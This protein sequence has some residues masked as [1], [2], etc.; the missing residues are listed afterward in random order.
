MRRIGSVSFDASPSSSPLN[1]HLSRKSQISGL[2]P[3]KA[4]TKLSAEYSD[5]ADIFSLDLASELLEHTRINKHAIKLVN[6]FQ[7]PSYKPIYSLE[8]IELEILKA[9][10]ETNLVNGFIK[11]SKFLAS[12]SIL[13]D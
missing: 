7:Q 9:Y 3:K 11:L 4:L 10:I 2:I 8:L 6:G 5:F 12:V 13:F 1:I